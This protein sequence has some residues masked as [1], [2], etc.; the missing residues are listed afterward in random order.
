MNLIFKIA[1]RNIWRNWRRSV[2]TMLAV[3]FACFFIILMKGIQ[4][5]T[6]DA[7]IK[8]TLD[9]FTGYLQVQYKGYQDNPALNK[10]FSMDLE[11][12]SNLQND[13][14][15]KGFAPRVTSFGL[16]GHKEKSLGTAIIGVDPSREMLFSQLATKVK[17]GKFLM[18]D[19]NEKIIV[20]ERMLKN[21][22]A[23]IGDTVVILAQAFDGTM[24]NKK[25][26]ING[27]FR[28]GSNELDG[29]SI[30]MN[31]R[32]ADE[33][34]AMNNRINS[35][36]IFLHNIKDINSVKM[37]L[38]AMAQKKSDKKLEI[39]PWEEILKDLKQTFD[40]KIISEVFYIGIL[41]MIVG[42]GILNTVLM[43]ITERFNEF[44]VML[45]LG[46]KHYIII[47]AVFIETMIITILG[48]LFGFGLGY[49]VNS[50]IV[51][52]PILLPGNF[53]KL[54]EEYGFLPEIHSTVAN[55]IFTS[56]GTIIFIVALI[57]FI[58]PAFKLMKLTALK[59]IRYT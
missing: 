23:K 49:G 33:I 47:A 8:T 2:L 11:M 6:F 9:L 31:I 16:I 39:L 20:G 34:L 52:N 5:G 7:N 56:T 15:I 17:K 13:I 35:I 14:N 54:Y 55:N 25:Y 24:G 26:I 48:I 19:D 36:A 4:Q 22:D 38:N 42:F 58:Y 59:G 37:N 1:W 57:V 32:A 45:A 43:S 30:F 12:L 28:F 10:S 29:M 46:T 18:A 40:M 51:D 21:L 53:T 27:S 50:Y 3:I 44:G 41:V